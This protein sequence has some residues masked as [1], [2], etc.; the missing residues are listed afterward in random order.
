MACEDASIP[1]PTVV[2]FS[3]RGLQSKWVLN[4]PVPSAVLPRWREVQSVLCRRLLHLGADA[5]ALDASRV[6]RLVGTTNSR[7]GDTVREV[8][9]ANVVANGATRRIDGAL[10]YDFDVFADT[11]LP[12]ARAELERR[13]AQRAE[14][15]NV[16]LD[17]KQGRDELRRA[18]GV[19]GSSVD[20]KGDPSAK[21][22]TG[23]PLVPSKLAWDRLGDLRRLA[24]LRGWQGGVPPGNR[25]AFLFLGAAFLAASR[26]AS[27]FS[28]EVETLAR[29]FAPTWSAQERRSCVSSVVALLEATRRGEELSFGG[30]RVDP[31]YRFRN[32]T[33]VDWL[34]ISADEQKEMTCI[35]GT[36]EARLRDA[37]RK[38]RERAASGCL[39]RENY[40]AQAD[41]KRQA[42]RA[43]QQRGMNQ[44]QIAVALAISPATASRYCRS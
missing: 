2:V 9:R 12:L 37:A 5:K 34:S 35:I 43:L 31:Q 6:L 23:Y 10:V 36:T 14:L 4:H 17:D 16:E 42:A 22:H 21:N 27:S 19:M 25:D 15:M 1:Y 33:L 26:L 7:S 30:R 32:E 41:E 8:Y 44:A 38:R 3:G 18:E 20:A 11:V 39:S 24:A 40:L 13:R 29:Q 28:A